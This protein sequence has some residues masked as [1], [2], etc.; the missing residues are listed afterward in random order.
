MRSSSRSLANASFLSIDLQE[1]REVP[2]GEEVYVTVEEAFQRVGGFGCWQVASIVVNTCANG[3]A[4]F[5][6]YAFAFLEKEPQFMCQLNGD[7]DI[8]TS[9]TEARPLKE[10]Y[11]AKVVPCEIDWSSQESI[12]NLMTQLDFYCKSKVMLGF[13]GFSFLLGIVI[14]C[15][16]ITRFGDIYGR[17][18]IYAIG[19]FL[20]IIVMVCLLISRHIPLDY[21]LLFFLG[22]SVTMRYYV[23]YTYGIEMQ[24]ASHAVFASTI[25]FLFE[26]FA[27]LFICIYFLH[28]SKDWRPLQIPNLVMS[29]LGLGCLIWMPETPAFLVSQKRHAEARQVFAMIAKWNGKGSDVAPFFVFLKSDKDREESSE[30]ENNS[31]GVKVSVKKIM[32]DKI[33]RHNLLASCILWLFASFNFYMITFY[34]KYFPGNIFQNSICFALSDM[35]GFFLAGVLLKA[36]RTG[37]ALRFSYLI[38]SFGGLFYM[39]FGKTYPAFLPLFI[40]CVRV[41][42]TMSF[43]IGYISVPRLFP[44]RYVSLVYAITNVVAHVFACFAPLVAEVPDPTPFLCLMMA[45]VCMLVTSYYV[46]ELTAIRTEEDPKSEVKTDEDALFQMNRCTN[47][48]PLDNV[49]SLSLIS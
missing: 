24:P 32:A 4:A 39:L 3:G 44:T 7:Q 45:L 2:V 10:E 34:L 11:C 33:L 20:H 14:G 16:T 30:S 21:L 22:Y 38:S 8:W 17:K 36:M 37:R 49:D 28:L 23:G 29:V 19:L 25:M 13:V 15:L 42:C 9:G 47:A 31:N 41:G 48:P 1:D 43:N 26:S 46:V 27:Y 5:L 35:A 18:P 12:N 40:C 6:L